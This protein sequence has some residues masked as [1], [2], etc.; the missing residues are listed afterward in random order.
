MRSAS[1]SWTP[2]YQSEP[3]FQHITGADSAARS[4]NMR[5]LLGVPLRVGDRVI[6]ALFACK[7]Q[8]RDFA[9]SEIALLSALAAHAAIAIEN[10]RP[11]TGSRR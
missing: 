1:P 3:A 10:V 7:R 6:G 9:D 11:S 4:E 2:D 5:G 8:E